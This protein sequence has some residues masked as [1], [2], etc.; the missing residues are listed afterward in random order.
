[1]T[2]GLTL[3]LLLALGGLLLSPLSELLIARSLPTGSAGSPL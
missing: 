1:M 3:P 2:D